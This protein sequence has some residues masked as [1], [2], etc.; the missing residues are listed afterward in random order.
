VAKPDTLLAWYRRLVAKKFDGSQHRQYPGR[1]RVAPEVETLVV[2]MARENT[3]CAMTASSEPCPIWL[4]TYPIRRWEIFCA[5]IH[6]IRPGTAGRADGR[7]LYYLSLP[8]YESGPDGRAMS[9]EIAGDLAFR[10]GK[11][12][13]L[14][15]LPLV[16]AWDSSFD[17]KR[18]IVSVTKSG[19]QPYTVVMNSQ[20]GLNR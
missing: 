4:T 13:P 8:D 15:I 3:G 7:E 5:A 19:P 12:Q 11:P 10:A 14:G 20:A 2:R 16:N 1:P 17:A 6:W 18:F 9:V